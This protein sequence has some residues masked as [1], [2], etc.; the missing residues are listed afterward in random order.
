MSEDTQDFYKLGT[1]YGEYLTGSARLKKT[2]LKGNGVFAVEKI[3]KGALVAVFG[4]LIIDT[5]ELN[6]LTA[7]QRSMVIQIDDDR[8][9]YSDVITEP[10]YINHSC[11]PNL[12]FDSQG[13]LVAL[14]DIYVDEE[15]CFDYG[16]ADSVLIDEFRCECGSAKCRTIINKDDWKLLS[17]IK[18]LQGHLMPYLERKIKQISNT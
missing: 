1:R 8:F 10:D 16:S 18:P 11:E 12:Y 2:N 9:S 13:R 6:L 17:K 14:R 3:N 15:L 5:K 4:G 7:S